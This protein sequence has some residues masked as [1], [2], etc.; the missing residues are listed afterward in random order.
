MNVSQ[1]AIDYLGR[2]VEAQDEPGLGLRLQVLNPGTRKAQ[3]DLQFCLASEVPG[4]D[5]STDLGAFTLYIAG[6]SQRWLN[7]AE[8]DYQPGEA[9]QGELA[10]RAPDIKGQKPAETDPLENRVRWMLDN[11]INPQ[12]ASHGGQVALLEINQQSEAVLQF[13]GGCHGCGMVDVTLKQG[14][15][16]TLT[17]ALP[18]LAGVRDATDHATGENPYYA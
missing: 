1:S 13:G 7:D 2:L 10:I 5:Q 12:L 6:D 11:E 15:E 17:Q 18:D 16:K 9:G 4:T 3:C 14:I 8:I